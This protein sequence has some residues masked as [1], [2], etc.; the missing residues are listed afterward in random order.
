MLPTL[1][2]V[3]TVSS[4]IV[5]GGFFLGRRCGGLFPWRRNGGFLTAVA[6]LRVVQAAVL[7]VAREGVTFRLRHR[8]IG[9][10]WG[11]RVTESHL[12]GGVPRMGLYVA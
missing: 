2:A 10:T 1:L 3:M 8:V 6:R 11:A 7:G 5:S 4:N 12:R 9:A